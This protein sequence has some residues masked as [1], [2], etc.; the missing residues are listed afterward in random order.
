MFYSRS[1]NNPSFASKIINQGKKSRLYVLSAFDKRRHILCQHNMNLFQ[2]LGGKAS[3]MLLGT[4][5]L[6]INQTKIGLL[7]SNRLYE[8]DAYGNLYGFDALINFS[9]V[10]KFEI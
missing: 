4:K 10:W 6:L 8:G 5:I 9:D 7:A 2:E 3:V 1:I